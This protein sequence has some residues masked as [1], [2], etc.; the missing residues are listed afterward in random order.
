MHKGTSSEVGSQRKRPVRNSTTEGNR[1]VPRPRP[2]APKP[3]DR[4]EFGL[5]PYVREEI[6]QH[7]L[8]P[9]AKVKYEYTYPQ[10]FT[11][12]GGMATEMC[13]I[14]AMA[15]SYVAYGA[16]AESSARKFIALVEEFLEHD[17]QEK[18]EL[19]TCAEVVPTSI[20]GYWRSI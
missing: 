15:N 18:D 14:H 4:D 19:G 17:Y 7:G 3:P 5:Y 9:A 20:L 16:I 11:G 2:P 12:P 6:R 1:F 13:A 10:F 8:K